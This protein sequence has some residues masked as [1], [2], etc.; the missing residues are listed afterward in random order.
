MPQKSYLSKLNLERLLESE[1]TR[2]PDK[3]GTPGFL[4]R[5]FKYLF[6]L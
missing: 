4:L 3:K 5:I 2:V 6:R 1:I